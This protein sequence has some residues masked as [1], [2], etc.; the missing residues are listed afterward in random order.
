MTHKYFSFGY[1]SILQ[2][3]NRQF[4]NEF[5]NLP[6]GSQD[7]SMELGIKDLCLYPPRYLTQGSQQESSIYF[8]GIQGKELN[9]TQFSQL[10]IHPTYKKDREDGILV[11]FSFSLQRHADLPYN[12][13]LTYNSYHLSRNQFT[14]VAELA[15]NALSISSKQQFV[16]KSSHRCKLS[17]GLISYNELL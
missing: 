5:A 17:E 16:P 9:T 15:L 4:K 8:H 11:E 3:N 13:A 7:S 6:Q 14:A 2:K 12:L 10:K 1:P